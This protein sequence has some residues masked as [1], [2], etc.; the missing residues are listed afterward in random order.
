MKTPDIQTEA[1]QRITLDYVSRRQP[2]AKTDRRTRIFQLIVQIHRGDGVKA[3][4]LKS[5]LGTSAWTTFRLQSAAA[6]ARMPPQ[7]A[8]ELRSYLEAV[9]RADAKASRGGIQQ[10]QQPR[11]QQFKLGYTAKRSAEAEYEHALEQ[12][13]HIAEST[14]GLAV[15]FDRP[16]E[17]GQF[18]DL[19]PDA[20]GVPRLLGSRSPHAIKAV[21]NEE[22]K[23]VALACLYDALK[24]CGPSKST[25]QASP[26]SAEAPDLVGTDIYQDIGAAGLFDLDNDL[27]RGLL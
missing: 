5:V 15:W 2:K 19:T 18:G 12:L 6:P 22:Q 21:G 1:P 20:E 25:R 10:R 27:F 11:A 14:P 26:F 3:T 7:L 8:G 17:F 4:E 24:T 9:R 13:E 16:L 23:T